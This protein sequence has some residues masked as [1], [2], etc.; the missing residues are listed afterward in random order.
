MLKNFLTQAAV[1]YSLNLIAQPFENSKTVLQCR[2]VPKRVKAAA[3][4]KKKSAGRG[5]NAGRD[6]TGD[7]EDD[8]DD[9][10]C[11]FFFHRYVGE[12]RKSLMAN[13]ASTVTLGGFN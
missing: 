8:D 1:Q 10:V 6:Y 3:A 4:G 7:S 5:W 12:G 13:W 9:D 2:V 11:A